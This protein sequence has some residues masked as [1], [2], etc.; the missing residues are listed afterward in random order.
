MKKRKSHRRI[1]GYGLVFDVPAFERA[2]CI[3]YI[4]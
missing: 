2:L 1:N 3:V 4:L